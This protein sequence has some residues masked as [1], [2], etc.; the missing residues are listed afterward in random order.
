MSFQAPGI[1]RLAGSPAHRSRWLDLLERG[2][3]LSADGLEDERP[4]MCPPCKAAA[5]EAFILCVDD[6]VPPEAW[7]EFG[8]AQAAGIPCLVVDPVL[9]FD[10]LPDGSTVWVNLNEALVEANARIR[11]RRAARAAA[12]GPETILASALEDAIEELEDAQ[13]SLIGA[14]LPGTGR[15]CADVADAG[16]DALRRA[17][18][19]G[20]LAA[21]KSLAEDDAPPGPC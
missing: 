18:M 7:M 13:L 2:L 10:H 16:R 9:R 8:A 6:A 21:E 4:D 14:G 12:E 17:R 11:E 5:A 20:R 3:P 19:A 1:I 15:L